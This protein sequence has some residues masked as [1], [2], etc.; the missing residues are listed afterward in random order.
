MYQAIAI[1]IVWYWSKTRFLL[2]ISEILGELTENC[3]SLLRHGDSKRCSFYWRKVYQ[4]VD[5]KM[6]EIFFCAHPRPL[7]LQSVEVLIIWSGFIFGNLFLAW[8]LHRSCLSVLHPTFCWIEKYKILGQPAAPCGE[9]KKIKES[10]CFP[11]E[12]IK[13]PKFFGP[14]AQSFFEPFRRIY[15][16]V[17]LSFC[18]IEKYENLGRPSAGIY[19]FVE[20]SFTRD[21]TVLPLRCAWD[22]FQKS[23]ANHYRINPSFFYQRVGGVLTSWC[24]KAGYVSVSCE[25]S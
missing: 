14:A 6:K 25:V 4:I 23:F 10:D 5:Q 24:R 20:L 12:T 7:R 1:G 16:F 18:W 3:L 9:T 21:T 17:E 11:L 22:K 19:H 15:H 13:L 2:E 8:F